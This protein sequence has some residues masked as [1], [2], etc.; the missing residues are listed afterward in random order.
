MSEPIAIIFPVKGDFLGAIRRALQAS[1]DM[2]WEL[3]TDGERIAWLPRRMPGWFPI[4]R[5][6]IREAAKCAA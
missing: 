4:H 2:T 5:A 6:T 1:V 3:F